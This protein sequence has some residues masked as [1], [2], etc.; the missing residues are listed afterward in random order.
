MSIVI[1]KTVDGDADIKL[2]IERLAYTRMF[3]Q[4]TSG[5]G[6]TNTVRIILERTH[7]KV[8]QI[9]YDWEGEYSNMREKYDYILAGK[10]GDIPA[11]PRSAE[12]LARRILELGT[13]LIID[14]YA[15]PIQKRLEYVKLFSRA[16]IN[17]PKELYTHPVLIVIDEIQHYIPEAERKGESELAESVIELLT[18]GRKRGLGVIAVSQRISKVKKDGVSECLNKAIGLCGLDID[19]KRAGE[20]LGFTAK[21]QVLSLRD[22]EQ[23][24]FYVFGPALSKHVTLAKFPRAETDPPPLGHGPM[25]VPP[26]SDQVLKQLA[27]L[28][29]LPAEAER[30][31]KT[32]EDMLTEIRR[33]RH[34]N[35][36]LKHGAP[37]PKVDEKALERQAKVSHERGY[38]KGWREATTRYAEAITKL[39]RSL[40]MTTGKLQRISELVGGK[41]ELP[42]IKVDLRPLEHMDTY[43]PYP[44]PISQPP[45]PQPQPITIEEGDVKY[46]RCAKMIL[47]FLTMFPDRSFTWPQV[48]AMTKYSWSSGNFGNNMSVLKKAELVRERGDTLQINPERL[49]EAKQICADIQLGSLQDWLSELRLAEKKIYTVLYEHAGETFSLQQIGEATGYSP[50]SGNFGN[51]LS[52]LK[53]LGLIEKVDGGVRFNEAITEFL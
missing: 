25:K 38:A 27:K 4:A 23:G 44:L 21:E 13:S 24:V 33:L 52:R 30:E 45:K 8:Q 12:I 26:P 37:K 46:S 1:A 3:I 29:D 5:G 15:L 7:G 10:D 9:V 31:L 6:K 18:Q 53:T 17:S 40:T 43:R 34:D 16:L 49:D 50:D 47:A 2:D 51:S 14:L 11:D 39:Q 32:K 35:R 41:I 48:G 36:E 19:R 20:E 28:T 42:N 22:L